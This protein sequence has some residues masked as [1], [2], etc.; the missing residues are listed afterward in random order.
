MLD[1]KSSVLLGS[2][3]AFYWPKQIKNL[4]LNQQQDKLLNGILVL[5]NYLGLVLLKQ[6]KNNIKSA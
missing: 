1:R 3:G 6:E 2:F 5:S 4:K